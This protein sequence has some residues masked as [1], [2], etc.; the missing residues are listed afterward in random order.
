MVVFVSMLSMLM[1]LLN[2]SLGNLCSY[3]LAVI[4]IGQC[5]CTEDD[6]KALRILY[7]EVDSFYNENATGGLTTAL[8]IARLNILFDDLSHANSPAQIHQQVPQLE[9]PEQESS[10]HLSAVVYVC[11]LAQEGVICYPCGQLVVGPFVLVLS[12]QSPLVLTK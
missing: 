11:A 1:C 12:V 7:H 9:T 8:M 5:T 6:T 4:F 2:F 3:Q 10:N